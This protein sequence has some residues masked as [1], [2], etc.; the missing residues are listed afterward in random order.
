MT[1]RVLSE[2]ELNRALF[3]RQHL[4][5]RASGSLSRTIERVGSLQT[6]YA[7]AGYIAL[8]T[9]HAGFRRDELTRALHRKVV[10]Q[11]WMMR[12]TIHMASRRDFWLFS[13]AVREHRREAW[14]RG[15][16]RPARE[17]AGAA[18]KT[19][20]FRADGP[21]RRAEIV[22]TL[23]LDTPTWNGVGLWVDLVRVPPFGTWE[24]PRAD[25]YGLASDW[26][27]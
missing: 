22:S 5:E 9:R 4:L 13:A 21:K 27:G 12:T 20:R 11:A 16:R 1:E 14:I 18:G 8:R 17:A 26:L 24:Q 10:V 3:A 25:L 2:R 19:A 15:F 6:Q 23:G 7:P